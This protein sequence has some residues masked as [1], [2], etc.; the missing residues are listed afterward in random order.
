MAKIESYRD[1]IVWQKA[2]AL[3]KKVYLLT[4]QYPRE[5]IYGLTSQMRRA[6]ASV[7]AN[8]AEGR[9]RNHRKEFANFLG[10]A[11]GSLAELQ[12]FL[13]LSVNLEIVERDKIKGLFLDSME[14]ERI[15]SRLSKN[16]HFKP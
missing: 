2:M 7:P 6:A 12:T 13:I 14:L 5:E 9:T 16:L 10:Y 3:V 4:R 1:L 11:R 15:L 8:I